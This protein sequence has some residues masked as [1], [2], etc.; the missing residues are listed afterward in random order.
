MAESLTVMTRSRLFEMV[1]RR[2]I[3][4]NDAGE[5]YEALPGLSRTTPFAV[6]NVGGWYPKATRGERRSSRIAGLRRLTFF[7]TEC[8]MPSGPGAEEGDHWLRACLI[9]SPVKGGVEG[10]LDRRSLGRR[11]CFGGKKVI[12]KGFVE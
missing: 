9:S 12:Q 1:L 10:S 5:S 2:T 7:H 4:R 3:M 6:F 11:G 8:G